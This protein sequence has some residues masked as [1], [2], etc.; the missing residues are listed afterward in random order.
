MERPLRAEQGNVHAVVPQKAHQASGAR[1][2]NLTKEIRRDRWLD[3][4]EGISC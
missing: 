4:V 1:K 3:Q 2:R